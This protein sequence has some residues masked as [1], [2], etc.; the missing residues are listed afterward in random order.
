MICFFDV[1]EVVDYDE[2]FFVCVVL[3]EGDYGWVL[4]G[5]V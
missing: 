2:L 4:C 3:F 5:C 1:G